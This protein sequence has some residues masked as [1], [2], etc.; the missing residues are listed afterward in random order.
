MLAGGV[1]APTPNWLAYKGLCADVLDAA[2][3]PLL[4]TSTAMQA[5]KKEVGLCYKHCEMHHICT[6][7]LYLPA[8]D[9]ENPVQVKI[10]TYNV[11]SRKR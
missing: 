11:T 2:L 6:V 1:G 3:T 4:Y 8:E 5:S 10:P 7:Y 9:R